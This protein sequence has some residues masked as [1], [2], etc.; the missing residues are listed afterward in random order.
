M[1]LDKIVYVTHSLQAKLYQWVF[2]KISR[3]CHTMIQSTF[4]YCSSLD[5]YLVYV[6]ANFCTDILFKG[7]DTQSKTIRSISQKNQRNKNKRKQNIAPA[8]IP[9][10]TINKIIK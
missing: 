10:I 5:K 7:R 1:G 6:T 4:T 9:G 8:C 2:I 3:S